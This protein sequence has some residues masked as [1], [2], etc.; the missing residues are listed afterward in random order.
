[1]WEAK[2]SQLALHQQHWA[3]H[4]ATFDGRERV[5]VRELWS[6]VVSCSVT[7]V[8]ISCV[9]LP[10]ERHRSIVEGFPPFRGC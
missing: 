5:A 4:G 7:R 10:L 1:M 6:E 8:R 9:V 2:L 3:F